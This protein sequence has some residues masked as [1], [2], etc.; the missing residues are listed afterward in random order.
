MRHAQATGFAATDHDRDLTPHGRGE[1]TS[2]G[3]WLAASQVVP[4]HA[5]VSGAVRARTTWDEV[6]RAAGWSVEPDFSEA[7]Y[8][9][10][11]EAA[12]DLVRLVPEQAGTVLVLGH[13]PTIASVASM[14]DDGEGDA[15]ATADMVLGFPTGAVAIFDLAVPWSDLAWSCGSVHAFHAPHGG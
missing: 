13:N 15:A 2:T 8:A 10:S 12:L 3:I 11:P 6:R 1:A 4:D 9:A 14:V 7:L 5:L